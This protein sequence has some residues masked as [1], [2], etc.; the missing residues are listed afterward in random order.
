MKYKIPLEILEVEKNNYHV[1][2][3]VS[4]GAKPCRLLLDTGASKTVFD[5]EEIKHFLKPHKIKFNESRSVGLGTNDMETYEAKLNSV[6]IGKFKLKTMKVAVLPMGHVNETYK[7]LS[8]PAIQGVL[9]SD[10]LM[11]HNAVINYKK[12]ILKIERK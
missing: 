8:I 6:M 10:F 2:L 3:N 1:F 4:V 5:K 11:K 9:G 12:A 7:M